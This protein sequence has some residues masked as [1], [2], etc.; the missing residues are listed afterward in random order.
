MLL[1]LSYNV[2]L[3]VRYRMNNYITA[4]VTGKDS[5]EFVKSRMAFSDHE[6]LKSQQVFCKKPFLTCASH[7]LSGKSHFHWKDCC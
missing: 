3:F 4:Y 6:H 1:L 7:I 5:F 2:I